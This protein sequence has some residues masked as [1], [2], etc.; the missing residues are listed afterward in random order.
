M[1]CVAVLNRKCLLFSDG[2]LSAQY[3]F[4]ALRGCCRH[5]RLAVCRLESDDST[6][7]QS[8]RRQPKPMHCAPLGCPVEPFPSNNTTL[9]P[10][11]GKNA[12]IFGTDENHAEGWLIGGLRG[13]FG[14]WVGRFSGFRPSII[15]KKRL[16]NEGLISRHRFQRQHCAP[17]DRLR[18]RIPHVGLTNT[19]QNHAKNDALQDNT[20]TFPVSADGRRICAESVKPAPFSDIAQNGFFSKRWTESLRTV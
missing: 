12:P 9:S 7:I 3:L 19:G 2:W 11:S 20:P 13:C 14:V 8:V 4:D 10:V 15:G 5:H 17:F 18:D 16:P 6:P 1:H